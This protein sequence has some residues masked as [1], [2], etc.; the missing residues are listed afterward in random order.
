M[1]RCPVHKFSVV[2]KIG[3][4]DCRSTAGVFRC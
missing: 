3:V 1:I 2:R 4:N